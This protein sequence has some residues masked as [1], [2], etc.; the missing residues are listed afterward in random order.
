MGYFSGKIVLLTGATGGFGSEYTR[1][2]LQKGAQLILT[3]IDLNSLCLQRDKAKEI[4]NKD[5]GKIVSV[6]ASDLSSP[7]GCNKLYQQASDIVESVDILINNAGMLSYGQFHETPIEI[8]SRL[9]R[10]NLHAPMHLTSL[11]LP[12]MIR[13]RNGHIVFMSSTAGYLPTAYETAYSV[14]KAGLR[15]LGMALKSEV[16][17]QGV[18]VTNIYP[19]WA[20]TN[21]LHSESYGH[22]MARR[23][24]SFLIAEPEKLV[25]NALEGISRKKLHVYPDVW[26]RFFWI[27]TKIWPLV[28]NQPVQDIA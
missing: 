12:A 26:A 28:G 6:L 9:M 5:G 2:L 20:N 4:P 15:C 14:S 25:G 10:V 21:M 3:D 23:P 13:R 24:P 27:M 11:F 22:K 18:A 7:E 17:K 8:N 1:Q 19:C 16:G